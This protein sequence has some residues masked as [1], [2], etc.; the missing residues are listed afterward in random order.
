ME[1]LRRVLG[2]VVPPPS[3]AEVLERCVNVHE[4]EREGSERLRCRNPAAEAYYASGAEDEVALRGNRDAW[5][6]WRIAHRVLR[7]VPDGTRDTRVTLFGHELAFPI[8]AAPTAYCKLAHADGELGV[9]KAC[10]S[11]G[12]AQ[13]LSTM[14][15]TSVEEVGATWA[16][17]TGVATGGRLW[18]QLYVFRDRELVRGL[19]RRAEAA[20][21][22]ALLVTVDAPVLGQRERDAR[23]RF[24]LPK[25]LEAANLTGAAR[26]VGHDV[27]A[28]AVGGKAGGEEED[29]GVASGIAAHFANNVDATLTWADAEWLVQ[30]T[31][32][33]VV[34]KGVVRPEDAVR[35]RQVG[36]KGIVVSNHG[37]R[38][39]D[40]CVATLDALPAIRRALDAERVSG[41][42]QDFHVL[43]DGG[44]RRGTDILKAIALGA[45]A[46]MI[47]RPLLWGL[48]LGGTRGA[49][50]VLR[51][52]I[53]EF[54]RAMALAGCGS[55]RDVTA[56]LVV[57]A[58][59][60]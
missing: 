56:D 55:L 25:G 6:R 46:V 9:A 45:D 12:I 24:E 33:P 40:H 35:A 31:R 8:V 22:T 57:P 43:V 52:L 19:V 29:P 3:D 11:H 32:M 34:L 60:P 27:E 41:G 23:N 42:V 18:F 39:L 53:T 16:A 37:G 38:Q 54:M 48:A 15:T 47:G 49:D 14:S 58:P 7:G 36:C 26:R 20:G 5:A 4:I 1:R 21:C 50:K 17:A 44:V 59:P 13:C 30:L 51:L 2:H 10:A 28:K